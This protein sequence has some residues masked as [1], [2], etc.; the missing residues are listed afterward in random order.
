PTSMYGVT[1]TDASPAGS[2]QQA[3]WRSLLAGSG[4]AEAQARIAAWLAPHGAPEL[5][6][7]SILRAEDARLASAD[8]SVDPEFCRLL[9]LLPKDLLGK[10]VL[11][12]PSIGWRR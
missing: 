1:S 10:A 3:E 9:M 5:A 7:H 11:V 2:S 6:V 8:E 4:N 12:E